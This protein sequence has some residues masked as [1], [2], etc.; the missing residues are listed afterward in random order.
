[1]DSDRVFQDFMKI[2]V[3]ITQERIDHVI[4]SHPEMKNYTNLIQKGIELPDFIYYS[5][6]SSYYILIKKFDDFIGENL[7][8]YIKKTNGDGFIISCHPISNKRL[9][10]SVKNLKQLKK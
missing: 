1:M 7:I 9:V 2:Y 6:N 4:E 10:R 3:R 5:A 8:L